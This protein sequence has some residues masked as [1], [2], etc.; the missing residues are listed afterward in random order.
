MFA[1]VSITRWSTF[2]DF[3]FR[4][5]QDRADVRGVRRFTLFLT[6]IVTH[7]ITD[8]FRPFTAAIYAARDAAAKIK[9]TKPVSTPK[10]AATPLDKKVTRST[11]I[12][13]F[14]PRESRARTALTAE[15]E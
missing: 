2:D 13:D 6:V 8:G 4:R 9:L 1:Q 12:A 11:A 15:E 3:S 14:V 5:I 10:K 7:V